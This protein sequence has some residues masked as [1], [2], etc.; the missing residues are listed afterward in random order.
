MFADVEA[1]RNL[2]GTRIQSQGDGGYG[3]LLFMGQPCDLLLLGMTR[4]LLPDDRHQD[5]LRRGTIDPILSPMHLLDGLAQH[6]DRLT[7]ADGAA[8]PGQYRPI[9]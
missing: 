6:L 9:L 8:G 5:A 4:A 7:L 3:L 1:L 2:Q